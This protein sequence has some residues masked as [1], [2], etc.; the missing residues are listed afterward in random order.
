[1]ITWHLDEIM[2]RHHIK[3]GV[4]AKR[5][6]VSASAV[7]NLRG[8]DYPKLTSAGLDRLMNALCELTNNRV[9]IGQL[10]KHD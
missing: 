8:K 1:M 10:I 7:S 3:S 2:G 6:G 4:L 5:M 9:T